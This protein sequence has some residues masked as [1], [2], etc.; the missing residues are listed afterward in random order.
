MPLWHLW[1][2]L[3]LPVTNE[4]RHTPGR[5]TLTR[6]FDARLGLQDE[7][8]NIIFPFIYHDLGHLGCCFSFNLS[9]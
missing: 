8:N 7:I 3:L 1:A 5:D 9:I 2:Q 6:R 4:G